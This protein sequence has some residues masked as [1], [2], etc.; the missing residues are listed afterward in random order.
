MG[1]FNYSA[2]FELSK[3]PLPDDRSV[4]LD[5]LKRDELIATCPAGGWNITNLGAILFAKNL[6]DFPRLKRKAVRVIQYTDRNRT[7]TLR[8]KEILQGYA[9]G[10]EALIDYI[11]AL[12]PVSEVIEHSLRQSV[13]KYPSL[14]VRELVANM[15]IHQDFAMAGAGPMVELFEERIEITNPGQPLVDTDRFLDAPPHGHVTKP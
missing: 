11:L 15:L 9:S 1:F 12:L 8:E 5:L 3:R 6:Q 2:Y 13:L 10:F 14:A 4:I 7:Q